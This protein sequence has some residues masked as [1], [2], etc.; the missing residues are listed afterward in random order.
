IST[1]RYCYLPRAARGPFLT[2]RGRWLQA[3]GRDLGPAVV[4]LGL[5]RRRAGRFGL[6]PLRDRRHLA[7]GRVDDSVHLPSL[8][9]FFGL[10]V[11]RKLDELVAALR[12]NLLGALVAGVDEAVHLLVDLPGDLFAVFRCSPRSRPRKTSSSLW[13]KVSGPSFSDIP[14]SVTIRRA[15]LV[16]L[17]MSSEAPEVMSPKMSSSATRPPRMTAISSLSSLRDTR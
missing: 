15:S 5:R 4:G 3:A 6:G 11:L 13:P 1:P 7:V 10:E 2:L 16:A 14:H 12:Q 9:R 17:P 8:D